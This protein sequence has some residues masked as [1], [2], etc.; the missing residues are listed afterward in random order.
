MDEL[1]G[2]WVESPEICGS[3]WAH[4]SAK[5][6][7]ILEK[8]IAHC[9]HK[10]VAVDAGANIGRWAKRM[11]ESFERI[12]VFEPYDPSMRCLRKNLEGSN[13]GF[14][15]FA[16]MNYCGETE[17]YLE[18]RAHFLQKQNN[19]ECMRVNCATLDSLDFERVDLLKIDVD[20]HDAEVIEGAKETIK[21]SRPIIVLEV[22]KL[23]E[24]DQIMKALEYEP[25]FRGRIDTLYYPC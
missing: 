9:E 6:L 10:R 7:E 23:R 24:A 3:S 1:G 25:I 5:D 19:G 11:A 22:K 21:R 8:A 12:E 2:W 15:S 13:V 14:H 17:L 20:G 4:D 16:L 18:P